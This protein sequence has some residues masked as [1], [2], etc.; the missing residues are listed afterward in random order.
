MELKNERMN[1]FEDKGKKH[2]L[3]RVYQFYLSGFKAMRLGRLLWVIILIKLF[4]L[5]FVLR[6]FFFPDFLG[7][8]GSDREKADYISGELYE[9]A[10]D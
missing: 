3:I 4:V 9:R 7:R 1:E 5:F 8:F 2:W 10:I 6:L